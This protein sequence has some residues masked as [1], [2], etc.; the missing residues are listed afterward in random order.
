MGE[1]ID[2]DNRKKAGERDADLVE[3]EE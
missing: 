1:L 2:P 3:E